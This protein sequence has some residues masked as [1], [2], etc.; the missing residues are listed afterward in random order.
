MKCESDFRVVLPQSLLKEL[1]PVFYAFS[2]LAIEQISLEEM[3][4]SSVSI[5]SGKDPSG[6]GGV[7][8]APDIKYISEL[9]FP[10]FLLSLSTIP[11]IQNTL[12]FVPPL[13]TYTTTASP[14]L[15]SLSGFVAFHQTFSLINFLFEIPNLPQPLL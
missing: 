7:D 10:F 4:P 1:Q 2:P 12:F 5:Y 14:S 6:S 11:S 15:I 8:S 9:R 3:A 13:S